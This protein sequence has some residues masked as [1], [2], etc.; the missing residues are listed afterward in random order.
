VMRPNWKYCDKKHFCRVQG[1]AN[2][3]PEIPAQ[4]FLLCFRR[5]SMGSEILKPR[6]RPISLRKPPWRRG[7]P[8]KRTAWKRLAESPIQP[9]PEPFFNWC[10][11]KRVSA[12]PL[13]MFPRERPIRSIS[14][15]LCLQ[16]DLLNPTAG[17]NSRDA[18]SRLRPRPLRTTA[19]APRKRIRWPPRSPWLRSPAHR[20]R[21]GVCPR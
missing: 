17:K 8:W 9:D 15:C 11:P 21:H 19:T 14:L 16:L 18:L 20:P 10:K 1:G 4:D 6:A 7:S 3:F 12:F 5:E 13:P 2:G